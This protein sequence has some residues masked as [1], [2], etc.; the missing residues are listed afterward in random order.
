MNFRT[1]LR[2]WLGVGPTDWRL[3][4]LDARMDEMTAAFDAIRKEWAAHK[5]A[6]AALQNEQGLVLGK[7]MDLKTQLATLAES[8]P[9]AADMAALAAEIHA[10]AAAINAKTLDLHAAATQSEQAVPTPAPDIA[11]EAV[12]ATP[13]VIAVTPAPETTPAPAV[14]P[15]PSTEPATT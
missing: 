2:G 7:L 8:N 15:A 4:E 1:W 10:D 14:E 5:A 13:E 9:D 11:P 12:P 6:V 3:T